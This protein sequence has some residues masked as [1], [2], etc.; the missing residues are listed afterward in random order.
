MLWEIGTPLNTKSVLHVYKGRDMILLSYGLVN[1]TDDLRKD[2]DQHGKDDLI[3][4]D[5]VQYMPTIIHH[6]ESK[7]HT[8]RLSNYTNEQ[9]ITQH[10]VP[11]PIVCISIGCLFREHC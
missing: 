7:I 5:C 2:T 11:A 3:K 8:C 9:T 1:H 4:H 10:S 6:H